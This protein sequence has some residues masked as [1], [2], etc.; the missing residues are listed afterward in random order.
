MLLKYSCRP[1]HRGHYWLVGSPLDRINIDSIFKHIPQ[2]RQFAQLV[3]FRFQQVHGE[4]DV[5]FGREAADG[6]TDRAVRQFVAAA[7]G[8]QH[9]RWFQAGRGAGRTGRHGDILDRHDQ[10]LAF[11]VVEAHVQVVRHA[12]IHVAVDV[13]FLDLLQALGQA[14]AQSLDAADFAIHFFLGDAEGFAH[15]DDLVHRQGARTQAAL[16]A[17]AVHLRF[18][19]HARLAADVQRAHA[20]RAVGFVGREGHQVD[21]GLLQVDHDLAGRLGSVAMEDDAFR[22]AEHADLVDRLDHADFIVHQHDG[23]QNGVGT[24][25]GSQ[26]LDRDQAIVLRLQIG[27]F[28]TNAFQLTYRVEHRFVFGL[29]GDDVLALG[30]VELRCT[31]DG[32]V[33]AFRGARSPDDFTW[34]GIDQ[35][36]HVAARFFHGFFRGPA[37]HMAARCRIAELL[38]QVRNHFVG[39]AWIDRRGGRVIHVDREMRRRFKVH[40]AYVFFWGVHQ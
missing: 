37:I 33:V 7:Q 6:E 38:A 27:R 2:R 39:D 32:Q 15:A 10:R 24:H 26:L 14:V 22:A 29:D 35:R 1:H 36:R 16:M 3:Y 12:V 20:F 11:N 40:L 17:T 8:A 5:F 18:Q 9:V 19:A 23:D 25:G 21:L 31:L 30:F 4:V 28:K 34:V 13:D